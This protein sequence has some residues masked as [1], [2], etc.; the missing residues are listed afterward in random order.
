MAEFVLGQSL[1]GGP[2]RLGEDQGTW[3]VSVV[4]SA[5]TSC[6][7]EWEVGSGMLAL[8]AVTL[9]MILIGG[10]LVAAWSLA[11]PTR[12]CPRCPDR[13]DSTGTRR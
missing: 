10:L 12:E 3:V 6:S 4:Y 7:A 9:A 13:P 1:L 8:G 5:R 11:P 2:D